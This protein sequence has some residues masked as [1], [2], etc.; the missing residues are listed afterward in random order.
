MVV[1][2]MGRAE[3][4]IVA[5]NSMGVLHGSVTKHKSNQILLRRMNDRNEFSFRIFAHRAISPEISSHINTIKE[6]VAESSSRSKQ[7]MPRTRKYHISSKY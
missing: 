1:N 6:Y 5:G 2:D 3:T 4:E 7:Y